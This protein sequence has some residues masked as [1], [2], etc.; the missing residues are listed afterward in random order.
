M[1]RFDDL[2][3]MTK[4]VMGFLPVLAMMLIVGGIGLWTASTASREM[5]QLASRDF[6]GVDLARQLD[7]NMLD[8][9]R[10]YRDGILAQNEVGKEA[11]VRKIDQLELEQHRILDA[12]EKTVTLPEN[13]A[14]IIQL[15]PIFA[16]YGDLA[17]A[18]CRSYVKDMDKLI[19]ARDRARDTFNRARPIVIQIVKSNRESADRSSQEATSRAA[20]SSR[21]IIALTIASLLA[22]MFIAWVVGAAIGGP[23]AIAVDVLRRVASGD[24]TARLDIRRDDEVGQ[25]AAALNESIGSMEET[26][27]NVQQASVELS[28]AASELAASSDQISGGAQKQAASLEETAASLEE[29]SSTVR[30][31]ADNAQHAAQLANGAREAAERG[32]HV[33]ES[34]VA[35]MNEITTSSKHIA[36]IITTIDEI[37]FQTNLL[38]LNAAVEAAR[39]G[40]QGRGFS[41][42][43]AEVRTLA[44]RT[45]S[46]AKEI[47]NLIAD[48]S[49]K[50]ETGTRQVNES[51]QTLAEIVRSVK[52]V[53]DMVA[54]IAAASQEQNTGVDQVN[55]AVTQ[56]DQVTQSNAAQ[57]EELAATATALSEKSSELQQLVSAFTLSVGSA[58]S[59]QRHAVAATPRAAPPPL[60]LGKSAARRLRPGPSAKRANG[61]APKAAG[62]FE[63]F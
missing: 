2:K 27:S 32:G 21:T 55:T 35:A 3:T 22:S 19:A 46:A 63:E 37:A 14:R 4:L 48:S 20:T 11:E 34:A 61:A 18:A 33:V 23:L 1:K 49:A 10:T 47:R 44:Q 54:E 5:E 51:G 9:A 59:K 39:A 52:R 26:L 8:I 50:V 60:P 24:L 40:E 38:A 6:P 15:R 31:N 53:T 12:L 17:R 58:G 28:S 30:Q 29:I 57:T 41:V 16:E 13:R 62:G 56:V 43:A 45:A 7:A 25:M 42:V 36:D